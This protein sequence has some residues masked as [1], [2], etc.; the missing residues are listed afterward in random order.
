MMMSAIAFFLADAETDDVLAAWRIM[1]P[2][3]L[4]ALLVFGAIGLVT[5]L[6]LAWAAFLRKRGR[7]RRSHHHAHQHASAPAEAPEVLNDEGPAAAPP[8]RHKWRRSRR[9]HRA[10]NPTLAET[11][12]L[13]PV[14]PEGPPDPQ[15]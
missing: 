3:T 11:G 7:R 15:P 1:D 2:S 13:P 5:L 6:A 14:R 12:G 4:G 9:R 10:R 8:K